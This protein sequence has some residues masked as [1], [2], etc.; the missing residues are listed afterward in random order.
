MKFGRSGRFG[1][2]GVFVVAAVVVVIALT[3][4]SSD[5]SPKLQYGLIFGVVG[6]FFFTLLFLQRGDLN[7]A[8]ADDERAAA[9]GSQ[10]IGDPAIE[11]R[12]EMWGAG[13]RSI[14]LG[15]VIGVLIFLTVPSIYLFD[16]FIPL[17]IGGP[18]IVI[19]ALYGSW[20]AIAHG[21]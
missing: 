10:E 21:G 5:P 1:L 8:A 16:T 9:K 6:V 19:V 11:A 20:R 12:R 13:R 17:L 2:I 14:K 3:A 7:R 15:A 4:D 18:L